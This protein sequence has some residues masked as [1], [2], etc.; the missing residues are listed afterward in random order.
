MRKQR[1]HYTAQEKVAL[2]RRHLID[3]EPVSKLCDQL[4]FQPTVF[5][6]W[7]KEFFENGAAAGD[8][9]PNSRASR[10]AR[11][12]ANCSPRDQ[13]PR[14]S[15]TR[16]GTHRAAAEENPNQGRSSRRADGRAHG[17][18][19]K[20]LGSSNPNLD[21]ARHPRSGR[22]FRAALVTKERDHHGA[23][24]PM[25]RR[26]AQHVLAL[27]ETLRLPQRTQRLGAARSLARTL[28]ETSHHRVSPEEFLARIPAL[29]VH[30]VGRRQRARQPLE[31]VARS[32]SGGPAAP[33]EWPEVEER[34]GLPTAAKT[35]STL[36]YRRFLH[37]CLGTFYCL[38]SVLDGYSRAIVHGDL[39]QAMKETGVEIVLPVAKENYPGTKPRI[40]SDNGPQFI[41]RDFKEFMRIS[42]LTPV[43]TSPYCP[44]ANGKLE[45]WQQSLKSECIRPGTALTQQDAWRLSERYVEH[46]NTV[47]LHSAIGYVTPQDMLAG[48][49]AQIHAARDRKLE[50]ARRQRQLRRQPTA[51]S[52]ELQ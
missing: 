37:P 7:Q 32:P 1:K 46:Y 36:A 50:A 2:L 23:L 5:C 18:Q 35:A 48:R 44:Q 24:H 13:Q 6:R 27:A 12:A 21:R 31:R 25:A 26:R 30:D 8:P 29:D 34:Q 42:G 15:P 28:G 10:G 19:K 47:R 40:I 43:R 49:K 52:T 45:R 51:S 3:N 22:R 14:P 16:T 41:A 20:A 38:C 17:F 11:R 4:A 39:R 9:A 33:M